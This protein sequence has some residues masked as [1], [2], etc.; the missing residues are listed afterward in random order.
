MVC[1]LCS[2]TDKQL[3]G[4]SAKFRCRAGASWIYPQQI[5]SPNPASLDVRGVEWISSD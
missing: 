4:A 2:F 3:D 5:A 1:V